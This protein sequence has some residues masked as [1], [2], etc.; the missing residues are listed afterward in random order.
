MGLSVKTQG[1]R[2]RSRAYET[3]DRV[4]VE[5]PADDGRLTE[6]EVGFEEIGKWETD[7]Y[8]VL[9]SLGLTKLIFDIKKG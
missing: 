2:N 6:D 5:R 8:M 3:V 9:I 1:Q 7:A 4:V